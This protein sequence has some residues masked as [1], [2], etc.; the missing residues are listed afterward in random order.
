MYVLNQDLVHIQCMPPHFNI[1]KTRQT[2]IKDIKSH[3]RSIYPAIWPREPLATHNDF[4]TAQPL[5][6]PNPSLPFLAGIWKTWRTWSL[7]VYRVTLWDLFSR[8]P[9]WSCI[10]STQ[11][12]NALCILLDQLQESSICSLGTPP[13]ESYISVWYSLWYICISV[14]LSVGRPWDQIHKDYRNAPKLKPS[15]SH[16]QRPVCLGALQRHTSR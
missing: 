8:Q 14:I 3:S 4:F 2:L 12:L 16:F 5:C 10:K 7:T 1:H 6:V 11:P 15:I 13:L 9:V